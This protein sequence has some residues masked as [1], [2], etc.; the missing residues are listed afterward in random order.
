[1]TN[2]DDVVRPLRPP[3]A[4][5]RRSPD[6]LLDEFRSYVAGLGL[7]PPERALALA[8]AA[9]WMHDTRGWRRCTFRTIERWLAANELGGADLRALRVFYRW[10]MREG[11]AGADP[12]ALVDLPRARVRRP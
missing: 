5:R 9:R 4:G 8:T 12:T 2:P 6:Q 11:H 3:T 10:A 1:M 7:R